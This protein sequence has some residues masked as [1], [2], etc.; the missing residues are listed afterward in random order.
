MKKAA[1]GPRRSSPGV[2]LRAWVLPLAAIAVIAAVLMFSGGW[3]RFVESQIF[4]PEAQLV[5]TPGD[6]GLAYED[7]WITTSDGVR[8][9]GW[10]VPA[11]GARELILFFHG[12]AGNIS[13]RVDNLARLNRIG[14]SVLIIDY[15]GYGR[16]QGKISEAGMYADAEAA[17][18]K[19]RELAEAGGLRLVIFGRSLGG[20]AAVHVAADHPCHGL[21]L[22]ST[23]T[24]LGDMAA[25]LFPIPGVGRMLK[26]RMASISKIPAVRAP[27]FFLH[28]DR[29]GIVPFDLG[30]RLYEAARA[31]K[32]W[33]TLSGAGHNDTY[34]IAG[35]R[36]WQAWRKFLDA[37]PDRPTPPAKP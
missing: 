7:L 27:I 26:E 21:I 32:E 17:Y 11:Q 9:H 12:N 10:L 19:A 24:T 37:L 5:Q 36:Y 33:M 22:E 3:E 25:A 2:V 35:Q 16:S 14:A 23:F 8:L 4:F 31:P 28:G 1:K 30:R 18:H 15:R 6:A 34:M 20:V 29:D 13:H